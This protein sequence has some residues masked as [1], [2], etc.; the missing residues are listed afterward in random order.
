MMIIWIFCGHRMMNEWRRC[1]GACLV[2]AVMNEFVIYHFSVQV[3]LTSF[4]YYLVE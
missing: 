1:F 3:V 2:D 4:V